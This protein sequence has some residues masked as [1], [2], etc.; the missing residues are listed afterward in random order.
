MTLH[1]AIPGGDALALDHLVLDVNG[2]LTDRGELIAGVG[3]ALAALR[4]DLEVHALSA[5]TFGTAEELAGALGAAYSRVDSGDD[6]RRY[7]EALG[8]A[9]CVAIGNGR[10]DATML[11]S[12]ALGIAIVGPEGASVRAAV[13]ADVLAGS[14]GEALALLRDPATLTATLRA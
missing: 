11:L 14:I 3:D 5:D 10:N 7:V 2:T 9:R 6:K 13:A 8:P 1:I 4:D 12:A